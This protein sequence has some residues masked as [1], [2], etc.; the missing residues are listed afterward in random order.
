MHFVYNHDLWLV[1]ESPGEV[2]DMSRMLHRAVKAKC[3][4]VRE[5]KLQLGSSQTHS[6]W[7]STGPCLPECGVLGRPDHPC[8]RWRCTAQGGGGGTCWAIKDHLLSKASPR[9][10]VR[11]VKDASSPSADLGRHCII[12]TR[13][14]RQCSCAHPRSHG[15]TCFTSPSPRARVMG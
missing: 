5:D 14:V 15:L 8:P 3:L 7:R 13:V 9:Y 6:L 1:W 2:D 10:F 11:S 4:K 12:D